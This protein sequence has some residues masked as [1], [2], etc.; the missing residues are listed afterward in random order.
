MT[1]QYLK[2]KLLRIA[3]RLHAEL[4]VHPSDTG[5]VCKISDALDA[6]IEA[7]QAKDLI[8]WRV[9]YDELVAWVKLEK[10]TAARAPRCSCFDHE[11]IEEHCPQSS[12]STRKTTKQ[13]VAEI[14]AMVADRIGR[15]EQ[16]FAGVEKII[17]ADRA[18]HAGRV[19]DNVSE[20]ET[21]VSKVK[22]HDGTDV[23]FFT[24]FPEA[25]A[26]VGTRV[27]VTIRPFNSRAQQAPTAFPTEAEF[28]VWFEREI[29]I[30]Y[31]K[32]SPVARAYNWLRS[33]FEA[34]ENK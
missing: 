14:A 22:C 27:H 13:V 20:F 15:D 32:W 33:A 21:S 7:F 26:W 11:K 29:G 19:Y 9:K 23:V 3:N 10:E 31:L 5:A 6:A 4:G 17:E 34:G 25:S 2:R 18:A 8:D 30:E 24:L 28:K 1:E 12:P 16:P